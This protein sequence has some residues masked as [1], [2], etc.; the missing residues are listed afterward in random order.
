MPRA[1]F[2]LF[3]ECIYVFTLYVHLLK[4]YALVQKLLKMEDEL[5]FVAQINGNR[6]VNPIKNWC[7]HCNVCTQ[8]RHIKKTKH[9][10]FQRHF[11]H[12]KEFI[13][14]QHR[15]QLQTSFHTWV[16]AQSNSG[17]KKGFVRRKKNHTANWCSSI[18][19][20]NISMPTHDDGSI[21]SLNQYDICT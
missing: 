9:I 20:V 11:S 4:C 16:V 18:S 2:T 17:G 21:S 8:W 7:V 5:N 12:K 6:K 10:K 15:V 1:L 3:V 13:V 14:H 19:S